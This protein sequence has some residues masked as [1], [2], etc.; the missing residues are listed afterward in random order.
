MPISFLKGTS[1]LAFNGVIKLCISVLIS[2]FSDC[3][4]GES[5]FGTGL[6]WEL[7][8]TFLHFPRGL[9]VSCRVRLHFRLVDGDGDALVAGNVCLGFLC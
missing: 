9:S 3:I 5:F 8:M 2:S 4:S 6:G 1:K 7:I